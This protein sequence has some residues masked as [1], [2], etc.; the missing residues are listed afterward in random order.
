MRRCGP[1]LATLVVLVLLAGAPAVGAQPAGK[2]PRI[3]LFGL[4]ATT[5][6]IEA[7][8]QGLR[9]YGYVEGRNIVFERARASGVARSS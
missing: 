1:G 9:D 4:Q 5:D 7:F 8:R 6:S 2:L 3:G